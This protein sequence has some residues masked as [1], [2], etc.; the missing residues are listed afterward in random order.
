[1]S[2]KKIAQQNYYLSNQI[3]QLK[4]N[5]RENAVDVKPDWELIHEFNKQ[6]FDRI[7][8]ITPV[9]MGNAKE[10][11][12]I[13]E[14]DVSWDRVT[15]RKP[16]L[17][18]TYSGQ[19]FEESLFDDPVMIEL[20]EENKADIFTTDVIAAVLMCNPKSNYSFDVEI[21]KYQDKIF[22]DKRADEEED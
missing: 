19:T 16:K 14:Y 8:H 4:C 5:L 22:I 3:K 11:G 18:E 17:L 1:M 20:I 7:P 12:D 15:C 6:I 10:C 13:F 2:R 21:K 9:F